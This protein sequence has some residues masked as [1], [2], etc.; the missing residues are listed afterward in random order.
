MKTQYQKYQSWLGGWLGRL[1][2]AGAIAPLSLLLTDGAMAQRR[3][4]ADRTL[5]R[6]S[7]RIVPDVEI[8]G[9][10]SDRIEGGARR[11]ANLFHSF[12]EFNI[13]AGRGAYFTSPAGVETILSRV[14]GVGRSEIFGQLG[15]L[16][17]ANLF[18]M[19]PYGILFGR[20]ARL[21][22]N[23][24]FVATT[25]NRIQLGNRGFF[26]ASAP[27]SSNLLRVS[28]AAL[29][30]NHDFNGAI[31]N[32]S[33]SP[34]SDGR[35]NT[36]SG[37][38]GLRV[39]SQQTLALIGGQLRLTGGN[40]TT[41]GGDIHLGGVAGGV[42][43]MSQRGDRWTFNYGGVERLGNIHLTDNAAQEA[44]VVEAG[45]NGGGSIH[46]Q[47]H[48]LVIRNG[49]RLST[50]PTRDGLEGGDITIQAADSV[51]LSGIT[52][53]S[54]DF[55]LPGG[56]FTSSA[57]GGTDAGDITIQTQR[58]R[59][60]N[61]A[62]ISSAAFAAGK[63][64]GN[65]TIDAAETVDIIGVGVGGEQLFNSVIGA[66][67]FGGD[68]GGDVTI[69]TRH[70]TV[71]DGASIVIADINGL[72]GGRLLIN[73]RESVVL[74]GRSGP[75][76]FAFGVTEIPSGFY[77][78][79]LSQAD[80]PP[81][82]QEAGSIEINT[83]RLLVS[84]G[85]FISVSTWGR[86][87]GGNLIV[88]ASESV[89][90]RD[91]N[92][93]QG[94]SSDRFISGLYAQSFGSGTSGSLEIN[95][96]RLDIRNGGRVTVASSNFDQAG[97]SIETLIQLFNAFLPDLCLN[98]LIDPDSIGTGNA[99][100]L[101]VNA[102]VVQINNQS[103]ITAAASAG[104]GGN[105]LLRG[106]QTQPLDLLLLRQNS[107]ISTTAGTLQAGGNGGDIS[108][109]SDFI[110]SAPLENSD[111]IA[112]AFDGQGGNIRITAAALFNLNLRSRADLETL[113]ATRDPTEL[114]PARLP[115]NDITAI[116]Q[117]NPRLSGRITLDALDLEPEQG[118]VE[119]P[120][121]PIAPELNQ[122]C[123]PSSGGDRPQSE[124]VVIGRGGLPPRPAAVH[125][126]EGSYM[127]LVVSDLT[128]EVHPHAEEAQRTTAPLLVEAQGWVVAADGTVS[129]TAAAPMT[130]LSEPFNLCPH[131]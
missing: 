52:V 85:A 32:R 27:D 42:V 24:S 70:L 89:E 116:S 63:N 129:L 25:A 57:G 15:V 68:T 64:G 101:T 66:G 28:P 41:F 96:P 107:Q 56:V 73:A 2:L 74:S 62:A 76:E 84:D 36:L 95:S 127:D 39:P 21:D 5:G 20:H 90:I 105:I 49:A 98:C 43:A 48:D 61:G 58:L 122:V 65:T 34:S 99:G 67:T 94:E 45:V 83:R 6:E 112:N 7:T 131:E 33:R 106:L 128:A 104:E 53:F 54:E 26:S 130:P 100:N 8:R 29:W 47:A 120:E 77:A 4:I 108:I 60:Q 51:L 13:E 59:I 71:R 12:Q 19:N 117:T 111:I 11:G 80:R 30:F 123:Q 14:T 102:D 50:R 35:R 75:I 69:N 109:D 37:F 91:F 103:Q 38:P 125:S 9:V 3:P 110:V 81:G 17:E 82:V 31:V 92:Q 87:Q 121:Q 23:A 113:L 1:L 16:G 86:G 115:S 44:T 46:V 118:L 72:Q 114:D 124:F 10:L 18:L 78:D 55:A 22:V 119:L 97:I 93:D 88:N 79:T 40:L 126:S